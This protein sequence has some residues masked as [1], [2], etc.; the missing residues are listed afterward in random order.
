MDKI[1]SPSGQAI[2]VKDGFLPLTAPVPTIG[3][4]APE[5]DVG[6]RDRDD[7]GHELQGHDVRDVPGRPGEVQGRARP[8]KITVTV[9]AEGEDRVADG[10]ESVRHRDLEDDRLIARVVGR[11]PAGERAAARRSP[12]RSGAVLLRRAARR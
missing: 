1:L 9:P 11:T 7:D 5:G 6:G 10:D 2:F 8:T 4:L 3:K 12:L